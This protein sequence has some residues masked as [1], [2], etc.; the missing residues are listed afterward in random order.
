MTPKY[1]PKPLSVPPD[2]SGAPG[3]L[4]ALASDVEQPASGYVFGDVTA[5]ELRKVADYLDGTKSVPGVGEMDRLDTIT[6]L[7]EVLRRIER[8]PVNPDG[9]TI[10]FISA[11]TEYQSTTIKVK[12]QVAAL[13]MQMLE[14]V[15][16]L[17]Q[18]PHVA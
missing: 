2:L 18:T 17:A 3:L 16:S 4:R 13:V 10:A 5:A 15:R 11:G 1:F 12:P 8:Q 14:S 6:M 7:R 9:D